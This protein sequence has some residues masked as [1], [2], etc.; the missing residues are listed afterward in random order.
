[1]TYV[2]TMPHWQKESSQTPHWQEESIEPKFNGP[3]FVKRSAWEERESSRPC[4]ISTDLSTCYPP[5]IFIEFESSEVFKTLR[6]SRSL[7]VINHIFSVMLLALTR[8]PRS[9]WSYCWTLGVALY[10]QRWKSW[11]L[12]TMEDGGYECGMH[13][14]IQ[15]NGDIFGFILVGSW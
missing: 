8:K 6:H 5:T 13:V 1:M 3:L 9:M 2:L 7:S 10:F 4:F 14:H 11:T 15:Y 12:T